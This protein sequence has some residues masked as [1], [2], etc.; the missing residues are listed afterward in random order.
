MNRVTH[1]QAMEERIAA[2]RMVPQGTIPVEESVAVEEPLE[3]HINDS[4]WVTTMRTPGQDRALAVG[5]L[6]TEGSFPT[7]LISQPLN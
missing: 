1:A 5:L 3:I 4:P 6:Y 2:Q 7:H